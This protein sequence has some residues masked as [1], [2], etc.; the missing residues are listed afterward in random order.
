M[1]IKL[2]FIYL[3]ILLLSACSSDDFKASYGLFADI[4]EANTLH[5]EG[6][7]DEASRLL[8]EVIEYR[9]EEYSPSLFDK[10]SSIFSDSNDESKAIV[11]ALF[12][13]IAQ[14]DAIEMLSDMTPNIEEKISILKRV[15]K[16]SPAIDNIAT[17]YTEQLKVERGTQKDYTALE[18]NLP[19]LCSKYSKRY[20]EYT[21]ALKIPFAFQPS[22]GDIIL[23][24]YHKKWALM[25]DLLINHDKLYG[26]DKTFEYFDTIL[27]S[28]GA[29][30]EAYTK[31][32]LKA[33]MSFGGSPKY[34]YDSGMTYDIF[35]ELSEH[36]DDLSVKIIS[37]ATRWVDN[38]LIL[39]T[40]KTIGDLVFA[41][42]NIVLYN[43]S[44]W[45]VYPSYLIDTKTLVTMNDEEIINR[46]PDQPINFNSI[47]V[48]KPLLCAVLYK[49]DK[50]DIVPRVLEAEQYTIQDT[51]VRKG[52]ENGVHCVIKLASNYEEKRLYGEDGSALCDSAGVHCSIIEH[53][54][55]CSVH[56]D[57]NER[58][59]R[60]SYRI[61]KD[62]KYYS[63]DENDR[64]KSI[65][66]NQ[67]ATFYE[68]LDSSV[69]VI[70]QN[71]ENNT[72]TVRTER[73]YQLAPLPVIEDRV[74][75]GLYRNLETLDTTYLLE[76]TRYTRDG[77]FY[78]EPNLWAIEQY[79]Y[80]ETGRLIG[81]Q[82]FDRNQTCVE[83]EFYDYATNTVQINYYDDDN[84][85]QTIIKD[86]DEYRQ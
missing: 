55:T 21:D 48:N 45:S 34:S 8:E 1:R 86:I 17:Q 59:Q 74:Y 77:A 71:W 12:C 64:L 19:R 26:Y 16:L 66:D 14:L 10:I 42:D 22:A 72:T 5:N 81:H 31:A 29:S 35:R 78:D 63:Y 67:T 83:S 7:D 60:I 28:H 2:T 85:P 73:S 27:S 30:A 33:Y 52:Y 25:N 82:Y 58:L 79:G 40:D 9:I 39:F 32:L 80:D 36:N 47:L 70:I 3:P 57:Y 13:Y 37:E 38:K 6:K 18:D 20:K 46:V 54:D 4:E 84:Q 44:Y 75:G 56:R 62:S 49:H 11:D 68:Y 24:I 76:V 43:P 23:Y 50:G 53:R 41:Y 69:T 65:Y 61:S 51:I 15:T